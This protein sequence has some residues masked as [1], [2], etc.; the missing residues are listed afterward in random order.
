VSASAD[1]FFAGLPTEAQLE[2]REIAWR[3]LRIRTIPDAKTV[4]QLYELQRVEIEVLERHT[5]WL[6]RAHADALSRG[7]PWTRWELRRY[8][9]KESEQ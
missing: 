2:I 6:E 8:A 7:R 5:D 9:A 4:Q 1:D 3:Y